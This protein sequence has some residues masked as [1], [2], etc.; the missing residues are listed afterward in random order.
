[1]TALLY[2]KPDLYIIFSIATLN[3]PDYRGL[4]THHGL[5]SIKSR[6]SLV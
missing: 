2:N 4:T 6:I 3:I 5:K 1:M